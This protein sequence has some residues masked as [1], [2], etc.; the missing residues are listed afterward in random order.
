MSTCVDRW[1]SHGVRYVYYVLYFINLFLTSS[2]RARELCP[3]QAVCR[4]ECFAR[5][6]TLPTLRQYSSGCMRAIQPRMYVSRV[7]PGHPSRFTGSE[8]PLSGLGSAPWKTLPALP[9][10]EAAHAPKVQPYQEADYSR[11]DRR[12]CK[13]SLKNPRDSHVPPKSQVVSP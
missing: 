7:S 8:R 13:T 1:T 9:P 5:E 10:P 2:S 3:N 6:S 4:I 12:V 11:L